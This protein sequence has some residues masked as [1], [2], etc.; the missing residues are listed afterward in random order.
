MRTGKVGYNIVGEIEAK[1]QSICTCT[2]MLMKLT[3]AAADVVV[4]AAA[5]VVDKA[6]NSV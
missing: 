6:Q 2:S 5:V 3:P 4:V 1:R